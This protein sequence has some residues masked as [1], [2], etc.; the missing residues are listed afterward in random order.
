MTVPQ[1]LRRVDDRL[2]PQVARW[3]QHAADRLPRRPARPALPA[4]PPASA[5]SADAIAATEPLAAPRRRRGRGGPA[6]FILRLRQ[7]DD[8]Y[9]RHGALG[10]L[11]EV[12][13]LGALA[14]ALLLLAGGA[15]VYVRGTRPA[16]TGDGGAGG[17]LSDTTLA[18]TI[19]PTIGERADA[20]VADSR[21]RLYQT[22]AGQPDGMSYAVVSFS[23]YLTV[24]QAA[25]LVR[26]F[27]V[28]DAFLR[29]PAPPRQAPVRSA[30]IN[31]MSEL[32]QE[33]AR[34]ARQLIQEA[35]ALEKVSATIDN[36][37]EQKASNERDARRFRLEAGKLPQRDCLCVAGVVVRGKLRQLLQLALTAGVRAID[38]A[39]P[40][41]SRTGV[42]FRPLLPDEKVKVTEGNEAAPGD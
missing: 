24:A 15:T 41:A 33:M 22:A 9:A 13:Q 29:V 38:A 36:D 5:E 37:P 4:H 6:P 3:M 19:G 35:A 17:P 32:P 40:R 42:V 23:Q 10:L 7:V 34:Q 20:Y 27:E 26:G 31:D 11:R 8:R 2:L 14:L 28:A 39:P 1:R 18:V 21:S 12:P 30:E 25:R 16:A